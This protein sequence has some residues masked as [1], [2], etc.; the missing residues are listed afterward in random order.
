MKKL[1]LAMYIAKREHEILKDINYK[2]GY[3]LYIGIPFCQQDVFI[4]RLHHILF[5]FTK[6]KQIHML[7]H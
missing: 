1:D 7:M 5:H 4:A 6:I 3:S 2:H